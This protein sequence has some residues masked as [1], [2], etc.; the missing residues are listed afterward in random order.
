MVAQVRCSSSPIYPNRVLTRRDDVY[1]EIECRPLVE[2]SL[3]LG[4]IL[5]MES[6]VIETVRGLSHS[7]TQRLRRFFT[8]LGNHDLRS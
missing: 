4:P 1:S 3:G 8:L 7:R 6:A 5:I 2:L